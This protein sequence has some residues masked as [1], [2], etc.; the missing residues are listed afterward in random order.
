[1]TPLSGWIEITATGPASSKDLATA[2]LIASG[3]PG[4]QEEATQSVAGKLVSHSLWEEETREDEDDGS[5]VRAL[6]GYLPEGGDAALDAARGEL[7]R[8]GWALKTSFL[9]EADWSEEWKKGLRPIRVSHNGRTVIVK[10]TWK[11]IKRSPG[12]TIIDID[13]GMAF[14]TGGHSTTRMC[15]KAIL[16]LVKAGRLPKGPSILD[17]GTGTGVLAIA[18]MKLGFKKAVGTDIDKVALKVARKNASMNRT[19]LGLSAKDLSGVA[20][21]FD[22]VVANILAGELKRL[23]EALKARMKPNGFLILSG[24]L[25]TEK[26]SIEAAFSSIGVEKA[27]LLREK[28]WVAFAFRNP[29]P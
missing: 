16:R 5:P 23:S 1:M 26:D 15:L 28:E 2:I 4:V 27:F 3:S 19:K 9:K 21:K 20:G 25:D 12:E 13:P 17:V 6:K 29:L 10:P 18:A 14:G 24:I 8:I 11:K 22:L 7:G